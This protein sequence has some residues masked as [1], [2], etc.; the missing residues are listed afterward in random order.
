[1]L[2]DV[3]RRSIE[4]GVQTGRPLDVDPAA[5][6]AP[7]REPRATFVTLHQRGALRG[8][9][10]GLEARL[11]LVQDVAHS[12]FGAAF[13]DGRFRPIER[14]DVRELEIHVSILS[15]LERLEVRSERELLDVLRPGVDGLL[16]RDGALQATFLPAVWERLADPASFVRELK[17]KAGLPADHWSPT[18]A[19]ERYTVDSLPPPV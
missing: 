19:C 12:A 6:P 5:Y 16:L 3:A 7:L 8:C 1:M 18:L 14:D 15:A 2:L 13:R 17:R 9:V 4:Q 11:P 10:G